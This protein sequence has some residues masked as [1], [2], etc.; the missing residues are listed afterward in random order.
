MD[1]HPEHGPIEGV[2][3]FE[4]DE[5]TAEEQAE[6]VEDILARNAI[7]PQG[8]D[9]VR[10]VTKEDGTVVQISMRQGLIRCMPVIYGMEETAIDE[11]VQKM[12]A[13]FGSGNPY[14][15]TEPPAQA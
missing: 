9:I 1:I 5:P 7:T 8:A 3:L 4:E 11:L 2:E 12:Q 14:S 10:S 15:F 6:H 13:A